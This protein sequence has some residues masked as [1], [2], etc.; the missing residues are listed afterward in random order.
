[1][2]LRAVKNFSKCLNIH[3]GFP[4]IG[5]VLHLNRDTN[6]LNRALFFTSLGIYMKIATVGKGGS[7]KT[8]LAGTLSRILAEQGQKV[9]AIDG[10]P[11]PNLALTLGMSR[12]NA[13]QI[14]YIPPSVIEIKEDE[15]GA[16]KM[17]MALSGEEL[18][19][20]YG[21]SAPKNIDLIVMGAPADGSAG[22][23]CMCASHLAVRGVIAEM[24]GHGE[25]TVTDM[26]AGLE[27]LKRGTARNV[28]VMLIVAEPYYRSLEAA[29]RTF[30]LAKEL[31]IPHIYVA[32]NKVKDESDREAIEQ[33]CD[34]HKM[35]I[36]GV[37]PLEDAFVIAE[38]NSQAPFD[39]APDSPGAAAI[40]KIA[41][42]VCQFDAPERID[43][44]VWKPRREKPAA[45]LPQ[46]SLRT[47]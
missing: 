40:R 19:S 33:F 41:A 4:S 6:K 7:G 37:I 35:P 43:T 17:H 46:S 45:C 3:S 34:K 42:T 31:D 36:I 8:T 5:D 25:H 13:D 14:N 10:D 29:A 21:A 38:R 16:R 20:K 18:I 2:H 12:K 23:G 11:N 24:S 9:L 30:L 22:S 47:D 26:E 44:A 1:V 32:A 28:D 15:T 39:F 27:H